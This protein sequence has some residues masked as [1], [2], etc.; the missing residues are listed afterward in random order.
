MVI[1]IQIYSCFD[2]WIHFCLFNYSIRNMSVTIAVL[3]INAFTFPSRVRVSYTL[4]S[5][6]APLWSVLQNEQV[7]LVQTCSL[8]FHE[9]V[10][11]LCSC[12]L[13]A[14]QLLFRVE[15]DEHI[16]RTP[17]VTAS[18]KGCHCMC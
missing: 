3:I 5:E 15:F 6:I 9:F 2:T 1:F 11:C 12:V 16:L 17:M 7:Y 8:I 14:L 13:A 18:R 4:T 10:G